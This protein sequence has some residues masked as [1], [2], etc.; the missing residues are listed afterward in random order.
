[1]LQYV[2]ELAGLAFWIDAACPVSLEVG[3]DFT[4]CN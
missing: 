2:A 4:G 3:P 1:M